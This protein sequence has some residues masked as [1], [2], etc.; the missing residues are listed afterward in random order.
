MSNFLTGLA[1][2]WLGH[3]I[4]KNV[5]Y[6]SSWHCVV[7]MALYEALPANLTSDEEAAH[8]SCNEAAAAFME[9]AF[10][11]DTSKEQK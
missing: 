10:G 2:R 4:R 3:Q 11:V 9:V 7:A 1:Y 5:M 8:V 6:A